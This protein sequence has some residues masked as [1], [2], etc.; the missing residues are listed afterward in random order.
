[1]KPMNFRHRWVLVTG[2]S[3]GLGLEIARTLARDHGAHIIAV[4]RREERLLALK[5][6]LESQYG[7]Q[8]LPMAADLSRSSEVTRLFERAT[9]GRRV[10]GVVLNAGVTYYGHALEERPE[11]F[12]ALLAT[13]V[14]SLVHLSKRFA[15][16]LIEQGE[17]G[18][19]LLVSSI[20]CF[21]PLPYQLS[22]GATKSFVT[23][24]GRGLNQEVR[25]AGVSVS[26][27]APGGIATE[28]MQT[29]GL[30]RNFGDDDLGVMTAERCAKHAVQALA[31]RKALYVPGFL[32]RVLAVAMK[33]V[34]HG[35][36][37]PMVSRLYAKGV[38]SRAERE[39]TVTLTRVP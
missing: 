14:T 32:N 28:M 20:G 2:A 17:Q 13:N 5:A 16:Y 4:A 6:E 15:S 3:S 27:F 24:Y 29:S 12:E 8:V 11:E 31:R 21:S 35:F 19:I 23:S 1:M 25:G 37:L 36:V 7:V 38:Q 22:Y 26:V 30:S 39:V 9:E 33:L 18:G 10:Y 34:P